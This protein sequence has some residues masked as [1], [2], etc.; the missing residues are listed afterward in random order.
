MLE[1]ACPLPLPPIFLPGTPEN[2][3]FVTSTI[4]AGQA[5]LDAIGSLLHN[6]QSDEKPAVTSHGQQRQDEARSD[7]D[8]DVGDPNRVVNQGR[9]FTDTATGN[10]I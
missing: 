8:R 7:P 5:I 3:D 4:R 10:T 6:E 1:G 2:A 9:K